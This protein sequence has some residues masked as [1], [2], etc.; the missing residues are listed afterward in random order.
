[1]ISPQQIIRCR[2]LVLDMDGTLVDST[3]C[4]VGQW[5]RWAD[6]HGLDLSRIMA[7]SHG[8]TTLET[9]LEIAPHLAT[10][11]EIESFER[12]EERFNSTVVAVKGA[13]EIVSQLPRTSWAVV[14]SATRR[15]ARSRLECAGVPVPDIVVTAED[16]ARGKPHPEP[17]LLAARLLGVD[18][19]DC[20]VVED[21]HPGIQSARAAGMGVICI[22]TTYSCAELGCEI[23]IPDFSAI[24]V[25]ASDAGFVVTVK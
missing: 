6:R 18:S 23:C 2:A 3:A 16:V 24:R 8:R 10:P 4:V 22:S 15:L 12:E 17:Y 21:T 5:Q 7:I 11:S 14:T 1:V 13:V 20:V 19:A 9:I 25:Q